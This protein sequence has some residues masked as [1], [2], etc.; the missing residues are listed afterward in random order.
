MR[1]V[2]GPSRCTSTGGS[3]AHSANCSAAGRVIWVRIEASRKK[4]CEKSQGAAPQYRQMKS[5]SWHSRGGMGRRATVSYHEHSREGLLRG[6][7]PPCPFQGA[8]ARPGSRGQG[9]YRP[10][11]NAPHRNQKKFP[12]RAGLAS[13]IAILPVGFFRR[14][15]AIVL[16]HRCHS[17]SAIEIACGAPGGSLYTPQY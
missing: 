17:T 9:P 2:K 6:P 3:N 7:L 15:R 14:G 1:W 12:T 16:R 11:Q 4:E 5:L 10:A 8:W 13:R